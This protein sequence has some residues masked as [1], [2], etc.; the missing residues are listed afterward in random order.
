MLFFLVMDVSSLKL[1]KIKFS[2]GAPLSKSLQH[3][4][5]NSFKLNVKILEPRNGMSIAFLS[6]KDS[7][8]ELAKCFY[9][10]NGI[11]L[12]SV[13]S[14]SDFVC[15]YCCCI[16]MIPLD[17][18]LCTPA[19]VLFFFVNVMKV[20]AFIFHSFSLHCLISF[21]RQLKYI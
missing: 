16:E 5:K 15:L 1:N 17:H 7:L 19:K 11:C 12:K 13:L 4:F 2:K 9:V 8:N 20:N 14:I 3:M 18:V 21:N 10:C 6:L